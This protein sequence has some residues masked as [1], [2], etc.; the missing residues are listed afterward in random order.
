[1][2]IGLQNRNW[3]YSLLK[4]S[5]ISGNIVV[6]FIIWLQII[7]VNG[8]ESVSPFIHLLSVSSTEKN[9]LTIFL[10]RLLL[11]LPL[12]IF[13]III[14]NCILA[15][16]VYQ[17]KIITCFSDHHEFRII[18]S[19][20]FACSLLMQ[21]GFTRI[22]S[23]FNSDKSIRQFDGMLCGTLQCCIDYQWLK[24]CLR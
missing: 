24:T 22:T 10:L 19:N 6:E 15:W 13:T 8:N 7:L 4:G 14:N 20:F 2:S 1:M 21:I 5:R 23:Q 18:Y 16:A 3:A 17:T 12:P 9:S 11:L